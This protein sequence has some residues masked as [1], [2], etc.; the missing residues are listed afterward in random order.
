MRHGVCPSFEARKG[1]HLTGERNA[2]IPGDDGG[3]CGRALRFLRLAA[4]ESRMF[5]WRTIP[6][7]GPASA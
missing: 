7:S 1:A 6:I 5:A 3:I 2:F 4:M